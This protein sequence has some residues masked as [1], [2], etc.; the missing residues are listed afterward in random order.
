MYI[1]ESNRIIITLKMGIYRIL[2][3]KYY[4]VKKKTNTKPNLQLGHQMEQNLIKDNKKSF[5]NYFCNIS[6]ETK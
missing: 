3:S 1:K 4:Y 2:I 5:E 6:N